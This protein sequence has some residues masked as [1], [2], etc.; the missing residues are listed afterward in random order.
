[1]RSRAASGSGPPAP[2]QPPPREAARG[3]ARRRRISLRRNYPGVSLERND[4]ARRQSQKARQERDRDGSEAGAQAPPETDH[5]L[6]VPDAEHDRDRQPDRVV[7]DNVGE[8]GKPRVARAAQDARADALDSVGELE[9]R[10]HREERNRQ[11]N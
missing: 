1:R 8:K 2:A 3:S 9:Y 6:S 5:A 11:G 7:P 4:F 10:A